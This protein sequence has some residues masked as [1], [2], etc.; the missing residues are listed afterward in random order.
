MTTTT[1]QITVIDGEPMLDATTMSLL[2]GVDPDTV[3]ATLRAD[4]KVPY[5]WIQAGRRRA[6]EAMARTGSNSLIDALT[7]WARHDLGT[8][9]RIEYLPTGGSK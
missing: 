5:E 9:L 3:T 1:C 6:R 2:F 4:P 7:Y 8:D